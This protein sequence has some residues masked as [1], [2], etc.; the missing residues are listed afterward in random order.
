MKKGLQLS[1]LSFLLGTSGM[2]LY[3]GAVKFYKQPDNNFQI[4]KPAQKVTEEKPFAFMVLSYNNSAYVDKNISSIISQKYKNYRVIYIDDASTDDTY[5]KVL[6]AIKGYEDH[7]SVIR[8]KK[9]QG[10]MANHWFAISQFK[11]DEIV[12]ILDGDDWLTH[13]YVL[14]RLNHYYANPNVWAT[15]SNHVEYP[16]YRQ[17]ICSQPL[18]K[19]VIKNRSIRKEP[20]RTSHLRSFY[21]SLAQKI[22]I[23]DIL[24][25]GNFLPTTYDIATVMPIAEM[26]GEHFF[27]IPENLYV[28]NFF[29]PLSDAR[30]KTAT[31]LFFDQYI[32]SL[33]SYEPLASLEKGIETQEADF[34]I[35]SYDRPLQLY[36]LLESAEKNIAGISETYVIYRTSSQRYDE[37]YE[38][39]KER[40]PKVR[41]I[42]QPKEYPGPSFKPLLMDLLSKAKAPYIL[43]GV[44]DIVVKDKI[45]IA[46]CIAGLQRSSAYGYYLRLG[47]HVDTCYTLNIHQGIPSLT[48]IDDDLY[49][50]CFAKGKGDWDYPNSIDMTIYKKSDIL[51]ILKKISFK[52][53]SNLEAKWAT[54]A[55][56]N[57]FGICS[58]DSKIVNLPLNIVTPTYENR[59]TNSYTPEQLLEKFEAG[60]KINTSPLQNIK[61][62]S[63]HIDYEPEF[64]VR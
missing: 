17:G 26:A 14:Q 16:D 9:N 42:L 32:R 6:A 54:Y 44:D 11:E 49:A 36:A 45:E 21:A 39:V 58:H 27:F 46:S 52:N 25:E 15:Y 53:P 12:I 48:R 18:P 38:M 40:F 8:N 56:H 24:Y 19:K 51:P 1:L 33:P 59:T 55:N 34:I 4:A 41:F 60:L 64:I 57:S 37:G 5:D 35:F 20:W 13:P 30:T 63:A 22:K 28:Y 23:N 50:W 2:L 43:F 10:A 3:N 47:H 62:I 29:N 31:Q 7:F 61:N